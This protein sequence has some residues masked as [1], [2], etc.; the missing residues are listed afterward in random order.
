MS[1]F[2]RPELENRQFKQ[3]SGSTLTL[4]GTTNFLGTLQSK[5]IEINADDT[6][7]FADTAHTYI[8]TYDRT[9]QTIKLDFVTGGTSGEPVLPDFGPTVTTVGGIPSSSVVAGKTSLELWH[10]ALYPTLYPSFVN[11]SNGFTFDAASLYEVG[12][13]INI[14]FAAT[15]SRGA[16]NPQYTAASPFRS[17]PANTYNFTGT[18]LV[19]TPFTSSPLA[20]APSVVGYVVL[21]GTN[22]WTGSVSY[23]AGVQP[24]DSVG[25]NFSSPLAAG[26]TGS[27]ARSFTGIHPFFYGKVTAPG[28]PGAGRPVANQALINSGNKVANISTGT[29]TVTFSAGTDDYIWFAIPSTSTSKT[30]WYV[31]AL[32][33]GS[34]GGAVTPA[35]N[36]F[37]AFDTVS[38]NSPTA[39]WAGVNYK[40]YIANYQ[41]AT[42]GSMELRNS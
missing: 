2:T 36:L 6:V 42:T 3:A 7:A 39:L 27:I 15:F 13:T 16:I 29:I 10:D 41:S 33:N 5:G 35:G 34:I 9:D 31:N 18:G 20:P 37:P 19:S 12:S 4:S 40:I 38:I 26:T 11:P 25:N 24:K 21:L 8:L 14:N 1:F 28:A 30:V 22:T 32:N 23:D 17:G